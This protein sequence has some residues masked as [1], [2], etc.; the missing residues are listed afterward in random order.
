M[1]DSGTP[2]SSTYNLQMNWTAA[3]HSRVASDAPCS[4][5]GVL[6]NGGP[7][8]ICPDL[9]GFD[10]S[11]GRCQNTRLLARPGARGLAEPLVD[12][13]LIVPYL[14]TPAEK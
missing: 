14:S 9:T 2:A 5:V 7:L 1:L 8:G 4:D 13:S 10:Q 12:A 11:V 3:V 6:Y